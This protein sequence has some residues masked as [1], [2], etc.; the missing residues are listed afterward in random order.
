MKS[1]VFSYT[2]LYIRGFFHKEN[3]VYFEFNSV[4]TQF[5]E[6]LSF[7][8]F[9]YWHPENE[10]LVKKNRFIS[11]AG[12]SLDAFNNPNE[13]I[14]VKRKD[15]PII[16]KKA[17][18]EVLFT[19]FDITQKSISKEKTLVRLGTYDDDVGM[20]ELSKNY[21]LIASTPSTLIAFLLNSHKKGPFKNVIPIA[22]EFSCIQ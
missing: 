21:H 16:N 22:C 13:V 12:Y 1:F 8:Y 3:T 2:H 11:S 7:L 20:K 9:G 15:W 14:L 19:A 5:L 18:Q 6:S 4:P 17:P 10:K